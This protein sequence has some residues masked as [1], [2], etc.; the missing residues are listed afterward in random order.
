MKIL[1]PDFWKNKKIIFIPIYIVLA[2]FV[3]LVQIFD[4]I[5]SIV[6]KPHEEKDLKVICAGN[7][8]IGGTGKTPLSIELINIFKT[9]G[10][11]SVIVKKK[12]EDQQDEVDLIKSKNIDIIVEK[13][14]VLGIKQASEK[15]YSVAVLDDGFQDYSIKKDCIIMC[16]GSQWLGNGLTIP[17]GPLRQG[18]NQIKKSNIVVLNSLNSEISQKC[19]EKIKE[20]NKD[21]KIFHSYYTPDKKSLE[22]LKDQKIFAFAG[23][24][25]PEN[26]FK[27]LTS[28]GL[29][30][31]EKNSFPDHYIYNKEDLDKMISIAKK[32]EY[33]IIT[34]EKDYFRCKKFEMK[35]IDYLPVNLVIKEKNK[36]VKE[37]EKFIL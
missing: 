15:K 33:K 27:L 24:G 17:A 7:I 18:F 22:Q 28:S 9:I 3:I 20:E 8:Y 35:E 5:K 1:T 30:V 32:K 16:F 14:R 36:F 23:I 29:K 34:T 21:I 4:F 13:N 6:V 11:K 31:Y 12:Y 26:F 25:N 19:E 2:P 10:L 37:L